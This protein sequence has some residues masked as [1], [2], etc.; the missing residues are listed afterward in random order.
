[1]DTTNLSTS[2]IESIEVITG[3][4]SV[5]YG[6]VSGGVVKVNTFK[7]YTPF[8][9]TLSAGPKTKLLALNK[10]FDMGSKGGNLNIS[11]ESTSST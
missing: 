5:E 6:D 3:I 2:N 10:G 9:A 7:G 8:Q 4:P 1:M 11:L